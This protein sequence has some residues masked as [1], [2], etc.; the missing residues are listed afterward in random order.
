MFTTDGEPEDEKTEEN[1]ED[2]EDSG[3]EE[4]SG[5]EAV[6]ES[7]GAMFI[8]SGDRRFSSSI[9]HWFDNHVDVVCEAE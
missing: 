3:S 7:L 1:K 5:Q 4:P 8:N 6:S 9:D 2:K